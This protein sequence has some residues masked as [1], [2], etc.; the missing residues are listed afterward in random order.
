MASSP[1]DYFLDN[2]S[3][4]EFDV[5][6]ATQWVVRITPR[7]GIGNFLNNIRFATT[8]DHA[9]FVLDP[10]IMRKLYGIQVQGADE[11]IGLYFAQSIQTPQEGFEITGVSTGN[12]SGG[13]L[14]S[15]V[16]NDRTD[17]TSRSINI[18]FLETN[19][20]FID[21]IIRPWIIAA[22][23]TGLIELNYA[24]SIKADIDLVQYTKGRNRPVRKVHTFLGCVPFNVQNNQLDYDA[25]KIVKRTVGWMY[26]HYKYS[27]IQGDETGIPINLFTSR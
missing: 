19:L 18:D 1:R 23:Y 21:G 9:R 5:P 15:I 11:G 3:R 10:V 12:S 26:N 17:A 2:L 6:Y 24:Q 8:T 14:Q 13:Y 20:D 25:E 27:L 4:W 7:A 22:S 16:G